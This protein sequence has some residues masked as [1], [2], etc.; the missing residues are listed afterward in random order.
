MFSND[1]SRSGEF[2]NLRIMETELLNKL[3]QIAGIG[4]NCPRCLFSAVPRRHS[5]E[6]FSE[7]IPTAILSD[8]PGFYDSIMVSGNRW[9]YRLALEQ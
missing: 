8:H 1:L 2:D 3:G 9:H 6:D 5:K 4:G 7:T